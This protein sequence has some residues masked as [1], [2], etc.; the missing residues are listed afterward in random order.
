MTAQ[1]SESVRYNGKRYALC[2][3]RGEGLF[4][5]ARHDI[6]TTAPHAACR[7]GFVGG[8]EVVNERLLL[9]ELKLWSEA[10]HWPHNRACLEHLFG[11]RLALDDR[12]P[13]V[14]AH[15]L[16]F[17]VR[18]TGGLLLGDGRIEELAADRDLHPALSYRTVLELTFESGHLLATVDRSAE[19][20]EMRESDEPGA[21]RPWSDL[22]R[23][24]SDSS[25]LDY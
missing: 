16:A 22:V 3:M 7:R 11:G 23:W 17:P 18:F 20:A 15:G 25:K 21:S 10:R 5:P 14:D 9:T 8:Y 4:D 6:D 13:A 19:M 12:T 2:G 1:V 24:M